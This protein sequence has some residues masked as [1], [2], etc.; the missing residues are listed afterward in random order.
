M[1]EGRIDQVG[2]PDEVYKQPASQFVASFIGSPAMNFATGEISN[3]GRKTVLETESG[4][5]IAL[6]SCHVTHGRR[7]HLG[8]RPEHMQLAGAAKPPKDHISISADVT[9]VEPMGHETVLTCDGGFGEIVGKY[10][11][12]KH[13][14][15]S[16]S[17][18]F[19]IRTDRLHYFDVET[20]IRL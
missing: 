1:N 11:G 2:T 18:H 9:V 14:R 15:P 4:V 19:H 7:V 17:V 16:D 10:E 3:S 6:A 8:F 12:D 13:F 20:G 5:A